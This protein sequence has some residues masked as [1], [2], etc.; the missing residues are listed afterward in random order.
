M[1]ADKTTLAGRV[2]IVGTGHRARLYNTAVT[3]RGSQIVA[4]CDTNPERRAV[5]NR[6]LEAAGQPRAKEYDAVRGGGDGSPR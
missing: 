5:H 1:T 4:L 6:M 3:S 2:G